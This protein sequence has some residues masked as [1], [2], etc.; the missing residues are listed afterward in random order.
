MD[1]IYAAAIKHPDEVI[2]LLLH[3]FDYSLQK[4]DQIKTIQKDAKNCVSLS[5]MAERKSEGSMV[6]SGLQST[7]QNDKLERM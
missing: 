7:A 3:R 5:E 4:L 6:V 1:T 2:R